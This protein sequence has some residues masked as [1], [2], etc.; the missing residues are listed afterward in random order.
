MAVSRTL[1]PLAVNGDAIASMIS[2]SRV[3]TFAT[4]PDG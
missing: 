1:R 3:F 4:S 2:C